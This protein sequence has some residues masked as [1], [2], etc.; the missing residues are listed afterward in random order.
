MDSGYGGLGYASLGAEHFKKIRTYFLEKC[1]KKQLE[2]AQKK[3]EELLDYMI[4]DPGE[5]HALIAST[6]HNHYIITTMTGPVTGMFQ[7]FGILIRNA[8]LVSTKECLMF[9]KGT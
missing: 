9:I 5:F 8:F 6:V 4:T 3:I 1:R 7:F 2:L